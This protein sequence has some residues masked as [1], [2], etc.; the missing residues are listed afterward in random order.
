MTERS[1]LAAADLGT[2]NGRHFIESIKK[3]AEERAAQQSALRKNSR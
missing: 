3:R 2:R 1:D